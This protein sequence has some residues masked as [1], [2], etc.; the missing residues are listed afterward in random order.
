MYENILLDK[1]ITPGDELLKEKLGDIFSVVEDIRKH[2][3][4]NHGDYILEWKFYGKKLGWTLKTLIKK[5][6][7]FFMVIGE[8][9]F[10]ITF[11]FGDKAVA[12]IQESDVNPDLIDELLNARKYAEGRGLSM[13]VQ[14]EKYLEDIKMLIDIKLMK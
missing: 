11:V 2:I 13:I 5:R 3:K 10:M 6:N 8:S 4:D 12:K 1:S 9:G 7:L 14:D